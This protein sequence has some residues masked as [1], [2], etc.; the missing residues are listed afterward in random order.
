M[1]GYLILKAAHVSFAALSAGGFVLR[2]WWMWRGSPLLQHRLTRLLPHI[3]DTLLLASAIWLALWSRQYPV[4][5][6]WLTA[7]VLALLLYI[8]LGSLALKRGRTARTRRW[9]FAGALA[10]YGYI[11]LVAVTRNP[12]PL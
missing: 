11:V 3:N 6:D 1:P 12:W 9:A 10:T 5:M 2:G 7:K 8:V 4:V